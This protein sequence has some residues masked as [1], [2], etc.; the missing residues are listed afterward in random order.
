LRRRTSPG[1]Q[2]PIEVNAD[3]LRGG[4]AGSEQVNHT[5]VLGVLD[6]EKREVTGTRHV[7][8]AVSQG[9]AAVPGPVDEGGEFVSMST[10]AGSIPR[11]SS[12][13]V[14]SRMV[15]NVVKK[16]TGLAVE[17]L[18]PSATTAGDSCGNGHSRATGAPCVRSTAR[19][20]RN[21]GS[22]E[23]DHQAP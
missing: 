23:R 9:G 2:E 12:A 13:S 19:K 15:A 3:D 22:P 18:L 16:T 8:D 17:R 11:K 20:P 21:A 10:N 7:A 6:N 4:Q 1:S 14:L 5:W